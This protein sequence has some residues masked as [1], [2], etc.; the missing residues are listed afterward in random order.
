MA[1]WSSG[2]TVGLQYAPAVRVCHVLYVSFHSSL[3]AAVHYIPSGSDRSLLP[4]P[5]SFHCHGVIF[6]LAFMLSVIF[7]AHHK[8]PEASL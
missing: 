6:A 2:R 1:H 3:L 4:A 7:P 5:N 8:I